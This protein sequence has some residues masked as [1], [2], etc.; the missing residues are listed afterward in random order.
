ME[1]SLGE[2]KSILITQFVS[3]HLF[4]YVSCKDV[5]RSAL[6]ILEVEKLLTD[7]CTSKKARVL[8]ETTQKVIVRFSLRDA[9]RLMRAL[10]LRR[11]GENYLVLL[12]DYGFTLCCAARDLWPLP[13]QLARTC[14]DFLMGGVSFISPHPGS[15]WSLSARRALGK[16]LEEAVHLTFKVD[17]QGKSKTN[18]GKLTIRSSCQSEDTFD[19][20]GLLIDLNFA[21][22]DS[23]GGEWASDCDAFSFDLAEKNSF[24][25]K[26]CTRFR[27]IIDRV[28]CAA[29]SIKSQLAKE[30]SEQKPTFTDIYFDSAQALARN[31]N[32]PNKTMQ[33]NFSKN[34]EALLLLRR[35]I[36]DPEA[37][38]SE[39]NGILFSE[40]SV[41][42]FQFI[43]SSKRKKKE[44]LLSRETNFVELYNKGKVESSLVKN[45][46]KNIE[47]LKLDKH[48]FKTDESQLYRPSSSSSESSFQSANTKS[49]EIISSSA[50][51]NKIVSPFF[52]QRYIPTT[53]LLNNSSL[54]LEKSIDKKQI[55][56]TFAVSGSSEKSSSASNL[57]AVEDLKLDE[58]SSRNNTDME[59][60]KLDRILNEMVSVR[61]NGAGK[62]NPTATKDKIDKKANGLGALTNQVL[63]HSLETVEPVGNFTEA[64]L[65]RIVQKAWKDLHFHTLLPTQQY[66]WPHLSSSGSVVL[67]NRSGTGRSWSYLPVLCS[68]VLQ[69]LQTE[70]ISRDRFRLGPLAILLADSVDNANTLASHCTNLM[71][72]YDTEKIKLINTHAHSMRDVYL[73]LLNSCGILV[74]TLPHLLTFL[75]GKIAL[76]DPTRLE[77]F[78]F[79]DLHRMRLATPQL[80][81]EVLHHL[82][83]MTCPRMQMVVLT[84]QWQAKAVKSIL[85]RV[86]KPLL[87]FGD[88]LEAAMYGNL[89]LKLTVLNSDKK[90]GQLLE[91]LASQKSLPKRTLICCKNLLELEK[92]HLALTTAGHKCFDIADSSERQRGP[93]ELLLALDNLQDLQMLVRNV[94]LLVHFSMP[95]S[96]AEF[97]LRFQTMVDNVHNVLTTPQRNEKN[98]ASYVM[99]DESNSREVPRLLEFF[100]AHGM[101]VNEQITQLFS[102][103]PQT[104]DNLMFCP[105]I[106]NSGECRRI[107]CNKRHEFTKTDMPHPGNPLQQPGTVIRCK[108]NRIYDPVH[109]AVWPTEFKT[110]GSD[111]WKDVSHMG[112]QW[113]MALQ[114]SMDERRLPQQPIRLHDVCVVFHQGLYH[115]VR[116]VDILPKRPITVQ[117]IDQGTELLQVKPYELLECPEEKFR[118]LPPLAMNI[119]L[120]GV[121]AAGEN[122]KWSDDVTQWVQEKLSGLSDRQHIQITV[123]FALLDLVFAKE[124]G[125]FED[126]Q[127]MRTS[128]YKLMLQKE[129]IRRGF[130]RMVSVDNQGP[131]LIYK[132]QKQDLDELVPHKESTKKVQPKMCQPEKKPDQIGNT[133]EGKECVNWDV[134]TSNTK[135]ATNEIKEIPMVTEKETR[136]ESQEPPADSSDALLKALVHD[137]YT[138]SP[139]KKLKT[140]EFLENILGEG[141]VDGHDPIKPRAARALNLN[142]TLESDPQDPSVEDVANFLQYSTI[143]GGAV[144]PRVKWHQSRTHIELIIE[145]QEPEYELIL[146]GNALMYSV[147]TIS[148]PQRFILNTL[149][150]V[151][152]ESKKQQGYYLQVKLAKIGSQVYW[153]T[154]LSSVYAQQNAHWL[155]YDTERALNPEPPVDLVLWDRFQRQ[156]LTSSECNPNDDECISVD[157]IYEADVERCHSLD[158][159]PCDDI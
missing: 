53:V 101:A 43:S 50:L 60:Y 143:I 150:E 139:S 1:S 34:A 93:Q 10:V 64:P 126:C 148:P 147:S 91:L 23:K 89:S 21:R 33:E 156:E 103:C 138:T 120:S 113:E 69:C 76:I 37:L 13:E 29:S 71:K 87:L 16:K 57:N 12:V 96:W 121:E 135:M 107:Q 63:A 17:Y 39:R 36:V 44:S 19:A 48:M 49:K 78:V 61:T 74:T 117:M 31:K 41:H 137:L 111:D 157:D 97:T 112:K 22:P 52:N 95:Q 55:A 54:R 136:K 146:D 59:K 85:N 109:M 65:C 80:V 122:G 108:V 27:K 151:R 140:H 7:Y 11:Q 62:Q 73:M 141:D 86:K 104:D 14:L 110:K 4:C 159:A 75:G 3:P 20:A 130:A 58:L 149:G 155:V 134:E 77:F 79:D 6:S 8:Y 26:V 82:D 28:D 56:P 116:I 145:Q 105:Y 42:Q 124:M 18:F 132:Q 115:R 90:A 118:T 119:F 158:S 38:K 94:E 98:L 129:L 102:C 35:T 114:M 25:I 66:A 40:S 81:D 24:G 131:R 154:L 67:I 100:Q 9:P 142:D 152:I 133:T 125:V 2:G 47:H 106:L 30:A 51:V 45:L 46:S 70:A 153:P 32:L 123:D 99:L 83:G 84:Q 5:E 92:L 68:A 15:T 144:R 128:V 127:T 88:F 72:I